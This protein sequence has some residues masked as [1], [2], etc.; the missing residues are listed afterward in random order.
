MA[1]ESPSD[2][3]Q[4]LRE[5][6]DFE[7]ETFTDLDLQGV[8]LVGK[9]LYRCTFENCNLQESRW[10]ESKLES[11]VFRG[12][13]LT[14]AQL[15]SAAL[16]GVRFEGSKLMGIDWSDVSPNLEVEFEDCNLR[17]ASFVGL[18]LR[19][20]VFAR[21]SALEAN[22][23]DVDLSEAD[24]S[25]TDLSGSTLRGCTLTRTDFRSATGV[26][27]DP[28]RNRAKGAL[29]PVE[30][31]VL[32]AQSLGLVVAGHGGEAASRGGRKKTRL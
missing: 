11:C 5:E 32:L 7:N 17:Y 12:C 20:T 29:V 9:E 4:R 1:S 24:F 18:S 6:E 2:T 30:A 14:R 19:R 23:L 22:F 31:A 21:C 26:F 25:G 3:L 16:R 27:I 8:S 13:D 28:A 15:A 10:K